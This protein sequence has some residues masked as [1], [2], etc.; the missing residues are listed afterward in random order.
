MDRHASGSGEQRAY[1][2]SASLV[3]AAVEQGHD[4][5]LV[6]ADRLPAYL[7]A[8]LAH[9]SMIGFAAPFSNRMGARPSS[10]VFPRTGAAR[11]SSVELLAA[12][13]PSQA[14]DQRRFANSL[15]GKTPLSRD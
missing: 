1:R 3:L 5:R 9:P 10:V 12:L 15:G 6:D 11:L 14:N 4:D 8:R 13:H 2:Q 7:T